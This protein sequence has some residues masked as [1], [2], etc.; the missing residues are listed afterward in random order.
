M[1][2]L[3]GVRHLIAV[4]VALSCASCDAGLIV[5]P[6]GTA[7]TLRDDEETKMQVIIQ[8]SAD[9]AGALHQKSPSTVESQ[10]IVGAL[11]EAGL[12]LEPMHPNTDDPTLQSFFIVEVHDQETA[13]QVIDRLQS[14]D[15]IEA[16]YVKPPD[17]MP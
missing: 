9:V 14:L 15:G 6:T 4:L 17:E 11:E 5:E 16:A 3:I 2:S 1:F 10:A 7:T 12:I 8:V 13:Q